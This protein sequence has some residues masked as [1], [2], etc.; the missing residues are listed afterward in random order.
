MY[1]S[2]YRIERQIGRGGMG[3]VYEAHDEQLNRPVAIKV[4]RADDDGDH[5]YAQRFAR[6]ARVLAKIR[7]RHTVTIHE[8]GE[9]DETVYL[10]T[11]LMPEGDLHTWLLREGPMSWRNAL[12]VTAQVCE[13]LEDTHRAG[14]VHRDVKPSN[15]LL[16]T[17][18]D[19]LIA[20]LCDYGIATEVGDE[21]ELARTRAGSV[22]GSPAYMPPERM[23][24][25]GG[26]DERGD[27]YA[28]GCLLWA[29][30]TGEAPYQGD[31]LEV[32]MQHVEG[33]IPQLATGDPVDNR[34]D[35]LLLKVM[36]KDPDERLSSAAEFREELRNIH[37][38]VAGAPDLSGLHPLPPQMSK[39]RARDA[40]TVEI[41]TTP[42]FE[43]YGTDASPRLKATSGEPEVADDLATDGAERESG[44]GDLERLF[45]GQEDELPLS[46][47][48]LVWVAGLA[49]MTM[50]AAFTGAQALSSGGPSDQVA[51]DPSTGSPSTTSPT[52]APAGT[53][54]TPEVARPP[55]PAKPGVKA[56]S[57]YRSVRFTYG[58]PEQVGDWTPR[59][60]YYLDEEWS[61]APQKYEK[62]TPAGG[63]AAC[64]RA[65]SVID[66]TDD[67]IVT[68]SPE[69]FCG[70]AVPASIRIVPSERACSVVYSGYSYPCRWYSVKLAGFVSG[71]EP[72]V[73]LIPDKGKS[74]CTNPVAG[75]TFRCREARVDKN[76]RAE[77]NDYI[78]VATS[79][80][81]TVRVGGASTDV[82][83]TGP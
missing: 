79:T 60:E 81:L 28:V 2:R 70:N 59:V 35:A 30:L 46:R 1:A 53:E 49:A 27:V 10:V 23:L 56:T 38:T 52:L 11:D 24:G 20:F 17:R 44:S 76:G 73:E 75:S 26:D 19:G 40:T 55:A 25:H 33:P 83:L 13:A 58:Q 77:L 7:S 64:V 71:N 39:R 78:R 8:H 4:V 42:L 18:S 41:S 66:V 50:V 16:W 62:A 14:I 32:M 80:K 51:T 54:S 22:V 72:L 29:T 3:Y 12:S 63:G 45:A 57:A 74:Y 61:D 69:K 48:P 65:R 36:A 21:E 47:R 5:H 37:S 9:F 68:S 15:V 34:F 31:D 82:T 43:A 6:E 67:E